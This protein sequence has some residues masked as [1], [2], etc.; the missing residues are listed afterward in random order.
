MQGKSWIHSYGKRG[1]FDSR[2]QPQNNN[3]KL[4]GSHETERVL[5]DK[6]HCLSG[7]ATGKEHRLSGR[8][9]GNT[10]ENIFFLPSKHPMEFW[11]QL[12]KQVNNLNKKHRNIKYL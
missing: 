8:V 6:E 10:R 5:Y 1:F 7:R 11:Y 9:T 4:V 3:N 12:G 2:L